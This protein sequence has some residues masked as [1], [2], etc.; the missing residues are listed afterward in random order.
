MM[1]SDRIR[2]LNAKAGRPDGRYILYWMQQSQRAAW[3]PALE[4]AIARANERNLPVVVGFGLTD[5]YPGANLRHYAFMLQGLAETRSALERRGIAFV[6]RRGSP[7]R[8]AAE[9][10]ADAAAVV[11]DRGY[12]PAQARWRTAVAAAVPVSMEE[13][14]GDVVVPVD[15]VSEKEEYAA[16]TIRPK[17]HR[18]RDAYLRPM[19]PASVKRRADRLRLD[20]EVWRR[21]EDL[22]DRLDI[23]RSVAPS[24]VF[25]GGTSEAERRLDR[26]VASKLAHYPDRRNDPTLDFQSG[27]SPYLHFGQI[28]PVAVALAVRASD[29]PR[30]AVDAFLEELIVRREL[31][32]NFAARNPDCCAYAALPDWARATLGAHARD[33]REHVYDEARWEAAAT[34]DPYWNAAQR[35]MIRTG[36]MHNYMRMYWGKKILEWSRSPE[37]AFGIALRL[38]DKY[39]LDGRDPNSC[40]GVAWCFGKHDRPWTRRPV[41]GT[42]RYM[43]AAGLDR[44][45]DM[46]DY[47][48][49]NAPV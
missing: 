3:N 30:A 12:M 45:F 42:V 11:T 16:R 32:M 21:P 8:V 28:S 25:R 17:L 26:F 40:A 27:L 20:G 6:A 4:H 24:T 38:N 31:S 5:A 7:D 19:T 47:V 34:Q 48:D 1:E 29:A 13:V 33:R 44:K 10:A 39:E 9:L 14:E 23:D 36:K 46:R 15:R 18:L 41:F 35:E 43:N 22:L 2:S 37:E 49:R